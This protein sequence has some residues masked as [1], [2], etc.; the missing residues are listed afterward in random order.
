MGYGAARGGYMYELVRLMGLDST[1]STKNATT[2]GEWRNPPN[3]HTMKPKSKHLPGERDQP[4]NQ[5]KQYDRIP[6][7]GRR[8]AMSEENG[9]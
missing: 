9:E 2:F 8:A 7:Q 3:T 5:A 4:Y 1:R 6:T